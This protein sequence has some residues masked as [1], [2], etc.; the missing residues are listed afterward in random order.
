MTEQ[1]NFSYT[2]VQ[3]FSTEIILG[4]V[5]SMLTQENKELCL[6]TNN[7]NDLLI[8]TIPKWTVFFK[9]NFPQGNVPNVQMICIPAVTNWNIM[10][11]YTSKCCKD[12]IPYKPIKSSSS[13]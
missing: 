8:S 2:S 9:G 1:K 4:K 5:I 10:L 13:F 6:I 7:V 12:P 11:Q 3:W